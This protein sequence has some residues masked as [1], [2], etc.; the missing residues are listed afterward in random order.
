MYAQAMEAFGLIGSFHVGYS[1]NSDT[2]MRYLY[3]I[4]Y[5][6]RC[7]GVTMVF[8]NAKKIARLDVHH[9]GKDG[10]YARWGEM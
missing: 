3:K 9:A 2:I 10:L 5:V 4:I 6:V 7:S 1:N 8:E